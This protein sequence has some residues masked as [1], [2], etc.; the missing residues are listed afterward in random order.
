MSIKNSQIFLPR[1]FLFKDFFRLDRTSIRSKS[2][3]TL[4]EFV[5]KP[6]HVKPGG[7]RRTG[8]T[9]KYSF[10]FVYGVGGGPSAVKINKRVRAEPRQS[11]ERAKPQVSPGYL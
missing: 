4:N 7:V 6:L 10:R 8:V 11:G 2:Y 3:S 9:V 5:V 1:S